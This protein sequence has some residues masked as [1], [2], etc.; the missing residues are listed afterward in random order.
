ML[1]SPGDSIRRVDENAWI[2]VV[3]MFGRVQ[4]LRSDRTLARA[5][6]LRSEPELWFESSRILLRKNSVLVIFYESCILLFTISFGNTIS[7]DFRVVIP[8]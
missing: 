6:S 5:R 3:S 4:S 7:G 8:S 2:G 1:R